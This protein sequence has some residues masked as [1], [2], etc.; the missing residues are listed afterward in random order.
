[1]RTKHVTHPGAVRSCLT[2]AGILGLIQIAVF[3]LIIF[4]SM[5]AKAETA[6][7]SEQLGTVNDL[8][9]IGQGSLL[10][11]HK[12]EFQQAPL[13]DTQVSMRITGMINRVTL[14]QEF[15]NQTDRWQEGIYVFPLPENAAVDRMRLRVGER[16][17]EGQIKERQAA[18]KTYEQAKQNG[19][20]AA[21]T[22]QERPNIFTTSVANIAPN[23]TV[24]VEIEYQQLVR[25]DSGTFS[26]RF[27]M[28]VGTRYIPGKEKIVGFS[29]S[30]WAANTSEVEDAARI[31]PPVLHPDNPRQN[32]ISL[33]IDLDAGLALENVA[34]SYH[35]IHIDKQALR[36]RISLQQGKV[37]ANRDFELTWQ[38]RP[39]VA[40]RAALFTEQKNNSHHAMVMV[41]PPESSRAT[42]ISREMVY[43]IDT[44][45]SMGGQSIQ[46]A[47]AALEIALTRLRPGDYFNII[48]FNSYTSQLFG[49]SRPVNQSSLQ[50]ALRYV[51]SLDADGGTEMGPAMRAALA[52][53]D[54]TGLLRQ[55]I[56]MTDGS[57]GNEQSL[58]DI[59][60]KK[61]GQSRLFT[62]GI[63]SA[64]NAYF[65]QR[66]AS[67]GRGTY[68]YI[69]KLNEV[70]SR[71]DDLFTKIESPVLQDISVDWGNASDIEMWPQKIP[72]LYQG[73]PLIITAKTDHLPDT[74]TV[75]G[76]IGT[77]P[78]SANIELTGGNNRDG[79][80]VLWARNK[81]AALM[82]STRDAEFDAIKNTIIDTAITHHLV[83]KY[84]SLVAVDV[85]PI[86]PGDESL[87]GHAVPA[88]LPDG[89]QYN[90][91]FGQSY[92]ATAT[93]A[94][95]QVLLGLIM[96][97]LSMY[98]F[99][100]H[101]QTI[102]AYR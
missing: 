71:M 48:Q 74:L 83:S 32:R 3:T 31:T 70:Q 76:M 89:W 20:R 26:L 96:L 36:Y 79:I 77:K 24:I 72:D 16:I 50:K 94:R 1:M 9:E 5:D 53:Q 62:V 44:S 97:F 38:P 55:V 28:V 88:H 73:E 98:Y 75:S 86:R 51:R 11:K 25:Y 8:S 65:M 2:I 12:D 19:Q 39:D 23:E 10:F 27:P 46:Q 22:E 67:Y 13:L 60:R 91:V 17:I 56:F 45:G 4:Y 14:I 42:R 85:T 99:V 15:T 54:N 93:D 35:P 41:M 101:R 64:P 6:E 100:T 40:P 92:P 7:T 84:T 66:A 61:L 78:W 81:I 52:N 68:T 57:I 58:F 49:H 90:K 21:L 82:Q 37:L 80:A 47:R 43:V 87:E 95:A 33:Q 63:G 34:S 69:G 59:I 30:G 18:K 29:G 102:I